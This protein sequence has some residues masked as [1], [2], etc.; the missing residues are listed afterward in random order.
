VDTCRPHRSSRKGFL[1]QIG[2]L[3]GIGERGHVLDPS[4]K[5]PT[6]AEKLDSLLFKLDADRAKRGDYFSKSEVVHLGRTSLDIKM[7]RIQE[8]TFVDMVWMMYLEAATSTGRVMV[9]EQRW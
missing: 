8:Y 3:L 7:V 5:G 1:S 4:W 6:G 9:I 2:G